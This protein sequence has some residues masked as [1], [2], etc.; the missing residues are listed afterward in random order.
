[1]VHFERE[2]SFSLQHQSRNN[3]R[4]ALTSFNCDGSPHW[5]SLSRS[6]H[7]LLL[8]RGAP[9]ASS[10]IRLII[11]GRAVEAHVLLDFQA[12]IPFMYIL[13]SHSG[14]CLSCTK[15]TLIES[16]QYL[17]SSSSIMNIYI[18]DSILRC[19]T[20]TAMHEH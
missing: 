16:Q 3:H 4:E 19:L 2:G 17:Q 7:V 9:S 14:L 20:L 12:L 15:H 18:G 10:R 8:S 13:I 5:S 1:M 11:R 6:C